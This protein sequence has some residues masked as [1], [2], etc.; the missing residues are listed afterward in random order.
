LLSISDTVNAADV[1]SQDEGEGLGDGTSISEDLVTVITF[2]RSISET[3]NASELVAKSINKPESETIDASEV[4]TLLAAFSRSISDTTN[5]SEL[6]A[7]SVEK[8]ESET[9]NVSDE[10]ILSVGKF[11]SDT[12]NVSESLESTTLFLR[13]ISNTVNVSD[14]ETQ[15]ELE[16]VG[17]GTSISEEAA[18]GFGSV[19]TEGVSAV[20]SISKSGIIPIS[21]NANVSEDSV[22]SV[23]KVESE[24][25]NV[26][27]SGTAVILDRLVKDWPAFNTVASNVEDGFD[28]TEN[29]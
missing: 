8:P 26:S 18:I 22:R 19:Q 9:A 5:V 10:E 21:N 1:D 28:L 23:G 24:T 13:S 16:G 14:A 20:E 27:D 17:D 3:V 11:E 29:F 15:D 4:V 12:A 25:T 2:L 6:V 7:K